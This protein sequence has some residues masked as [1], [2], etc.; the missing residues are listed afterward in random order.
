MSVFSRT[1]W[2]E[3]VSRL[4]S[5]R[6]L[7]AVALLIALT[8]ALGCIALAEENGKHFSNNDLYETVKYILAKKILFILFQGEGGKFYFMS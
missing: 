1:Y 5:V 7:A 4:K 2:K 6:V 3:A 8:T